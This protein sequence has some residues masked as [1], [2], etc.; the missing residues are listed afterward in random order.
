MA[1]Q[2]NPDCPVCGGCAWV[3]ENHEDKAWPEGCYCGA[4]M[5]CALC[6]WANEKQHEAAD[7]KAKS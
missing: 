4:G 2:A 1:A 6:G 7:R 3:C 5:P